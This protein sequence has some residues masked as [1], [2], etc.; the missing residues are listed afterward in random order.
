MSAGGYG[1]T[2]GSYRFRYQNGQ[3]FLIGVDLEDYRR[4]FVEMYS[5]SFNFLTQKV[6]STE[7]IRK[8]IENARAS[9]RPPIIKWRTLPQLTPRALKD[10][11]PAFSWEIEPD[12]LSWKRGKMPALAAQ[13]VA[14][15]A[16]M[17]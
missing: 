8:D 12:K 14:P 2:D 10:L 6:K 3:F 1:V 11:G 5:Q 4:N 15:A 7:G 17:E 16:S 9:Y 13:N